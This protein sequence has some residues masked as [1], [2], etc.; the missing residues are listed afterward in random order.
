MSGE[1]NEGAVYHDTVL[2]IAHLNWDTENYRDAGA[3]YFHAIGLA[4]RQGVQIDP[5]SYLRLSL[6]YRKVGMHQH[7]REMV[8]K[9][10]KKDG[11]VLD[12][13]ISSAANQYIDEDYEKAIETYNSV[14]GLNRSKDSEIYWRIGLAYKKMNDPHKAIESFER[15]IAVK[16]EYT[17]ALQSLAEVLHYQLKTPTEPQSSKT[18]SIRKVKPT[19]VKQNWHISATNMATTPGQSRN[20]NSQHGLPKLKKRMK[21][22]HFRSVG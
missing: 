21:Q 14:V 6:C 2:K 4:E 3:L 19:P 13:I 1:G 18:L 12:A 17:K 16:T 15:A 5:L 7:A 9:A 11:Q 10:V 22:P 20:M 8:R